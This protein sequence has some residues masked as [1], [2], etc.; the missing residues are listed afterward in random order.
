ML[1]KILC[2]G[3]QK[4]Q[5]CYAAMQ[6]FTDTRTATTEDELWVVEHPSVYTLGLG[7]S[8]KHIHIRGMIPIINSDRGGQVTY[9]GPG[10]LIVYVLLDLKRLSI[11]VRKL[12]TVLEQ[13]MIDTL[14]QYGIKAHSKPEAPGVYIAQKKIGSVG[15]RIRKGCCYHGLSFNNQMNLEPFNN[16]NTC[17]NA[18]LEVTQLADFNVIIASHELA[19]PVTHSLHKQLQ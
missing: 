16:I 5:Q 7:G 10:Q 13:A 2:L 18:G 15:L 8:T 12:V 4:Y 1:M 6:Y 19:I 9:H 17:G 14:A 11:G 3:L